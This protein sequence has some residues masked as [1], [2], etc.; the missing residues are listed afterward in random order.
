MSEALHPQSES[1][2]AD[3][4]R[5]G[6]PFSIRGGGTRG[7]LSQGTPLETGGLSGITM[8]EPGTLTMV[9]RAGT[10][11]AD[12]EAALADENQ[13]LPFEPLDMRPMVG[14]A[15]VPTIGGV[16]ATNA[17]G[18]RR[19][20]AGACRDFVLGAR[21]V[22]GTGMVVKNG[23]RVMKNVTGYDLAK[24]VSGSHGTLGVITEVSLKVAP[25]SEA[26]VL[27]AADGLSDSD[28][29]AAMSA[30]LTAPLDVSGAMHRGGGQTVIR[31]EGIRTSVVERLAALRQRLGSMGSW[32]VLDVEWAA[33]A[34]PST[35]ARQEGDIWCLSVRPSAAPDL[36]ERA[37]AQEVLY[38]WGGGRIWMRVPEGTK[39]REQLGDF[40]GHA[41]LICASPQ[42]RATVG[43]FH[44]ERAG[45]A[46]LSSA[47]RRK[48]DPSQKLNPGLMG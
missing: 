42:I 37:G 15:G 40:D 25:K 34:D 28:A 45:V 23:G 41:T 1:E 19:V 3:M 6:G 44:P 20:K 36:V 27:L 7:V 39:L 10:P 4:I 8:Y 9:V 12:I 38:D 43:T 30:A 18:S 14:S 35:L 2:L 22:D 26:V 29:V 31:L 13:I 46:K 24:L 11:M 21:F 17:S 5:A 32:T 33:C 48:F 47:L 16:V